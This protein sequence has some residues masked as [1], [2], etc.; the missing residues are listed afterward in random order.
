MLRKLIFGATAIGLTTISPLMAADMRFSQWSDRSG[1]ASVS[2][3]KTIPA[4]WS[5]DGSS[6]LISEDVTQAS[7]GKFKPCDDAANVCCDSSTAPS[8]C[9]ASGCDGLGGKSGLIGL[10]LLPGLTGLIKSSERCYDDFISPITNPVY[11]EDP[12]QLTEVRDIF[13]NHQIPVILGPSGNVQLYAMQIRVRLTENL[14]LIAVKDGYIVSKSPLLNDGWADLTPGLKYSLYRNAAT[15]TLLSAGARFE[16]P[17]GSKRTLQG[18]GSGV[19]DIFLSG[20]ARVGQ[21]GHYLTTSGFILPM[22]SRDENQM[23]YWSNHLDKRIT[24]TNFYALTELNW[25]NYMNNGSAFPLPVEGGDLF[26]LGSQ[27]IGGH[28]LV[29]NAYGLRYKPSRNIESGL[30]FEFPISQLKGLMEN[31][32][33]ADLIIRF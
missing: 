22:D 14:S 17:V 13:I 3:Q 26:N 24:G 32:I 2:Q 20:G 8:C 18:N 7:W 9:D 25:F 27:G 10:G 29:T 11:F 19:L 15:G 31:R 21:S 4:S 16:A 30:A 23:F 5:D 12:R 6:R 1:T 28:N 33:T